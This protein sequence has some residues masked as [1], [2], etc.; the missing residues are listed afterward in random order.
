MSK[1]AAYY[2]VSIA[3]AASG[4]DG[5]LGA[6]VSLAQEASFYICKAL[7]SPIQLLFDELAFS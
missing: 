6:I 1:H 3:N 4:E 7:F 2:A 5:R